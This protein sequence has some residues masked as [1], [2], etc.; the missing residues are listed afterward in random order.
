M[1]RA[2]TCRPMKPPLP[3]NEPAR[4]EALRRYAI[5]DTFPEQEFDDLARLAALI[6]GT[7]I[8]LVSFVDANRQWFKA[9]VGL[10]APETPRNVSFCAHA[11]A[12]AELLVIPDALKDERFRSNPLVTGEPHVRFYAGAPLVAQ[13]GH[14]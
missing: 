12:K 7:P 14:A 3:K 10:E 11:I 5:L 4:L 6:C 9:R 1:T 2:K 13:D 8:A